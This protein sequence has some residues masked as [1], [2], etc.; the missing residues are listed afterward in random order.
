MKHKIFDALPGALFA[1]LI[2]GVVILCAA[3]DSLAP[4]T[5][6]VEAGA[7][8][9]T[10]R[11]VIAEANTGAISV[12][13]TPAMESFVY[14]ASIAFDAPVS[15]SNTYP[16]TVSLDSAQGPDYDAVIYSEVPISVSYWSY[17]WA[18][19]WYLE[20]DDAVTLEFENSAGDMAGAQL[21]IGNMVHP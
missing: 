21:V 14:R 1:L 5:M 7:P 20:A 18:I 8:N 9:Q 17:T 6:N 16:I 4:W 3:L 15:G 19:P 10:Y 12:T 11:N 2:V 13:A